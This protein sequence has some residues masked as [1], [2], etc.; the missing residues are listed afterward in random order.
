MDSSVDFGGQ[1]GYLYRGVVGGEFLAD[2]TPRFQMN[3]ALFADNPNL[4]TYMANLIL[5]VPIGAEHR[6]Q[7]YV[8]GGF[9]S[10]Q[11][12][13][14]V[15]A[16]ITTPSSGQTSANAMVGGG[17]LG[18]GVLG[19]AGNVGIRG[20]V[21]YFRAFTDNALINGD[22]AADVFARSA[23]SG[24]DFWRANIGVAVRW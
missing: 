14:N 1:L 7:P 9:G 3:N 2:F 23:L 20:D 4:N 16:S 24:L 10:M 15:L 5:A 18:V 13:S 22:S 6:V 21:R 17:D 8:S 12:R 11:L 19:Y